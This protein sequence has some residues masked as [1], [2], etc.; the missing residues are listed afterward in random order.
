MKRNEDNWL[1]C[2]WFIGR[3]SEN[4]I[5]KY[6]LDNNQIINIIGTKGIKAIQAKSFSTE[7]NAGLDWKLDNFNFST[8]R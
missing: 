2:K 5:T 7:T 4:S 6:Q 1:I 3:L 8:R